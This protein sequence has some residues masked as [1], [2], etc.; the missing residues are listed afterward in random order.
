MA[1]K[2][3]LL[4]RAPG[5]IALLVSLVPHGAALPTELSHDTPSIQAPHLPD[6][7]VTAQ[8]DQSSPNVVQHPAAHTGGWGGSCTC[9]N[10]ET[11]W[12]GDLQDTCKNL[13]CFG[14]V[15]GECNSRVEDKWAYRAAFCAANQAE[16]TSVDCSNAIKSGWAIREQQDPPRGV[17][18]AW[19]VLTPQ[20]LYAFGSGAA[21]SGT[22]AED[23]DLRQV[24]NVRPASDI[25]QRPFSFAVE[26]PGR[27]PF[28]AIAMS[29]DDCMQWVLAIRK[30]KSALTYTPAK[31]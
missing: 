22:P 15:A 2:P 3:F 8:D 27:P 13:A 5:V 10:G 30:A 18:K 28:L 9:P 21:C 4:V 6:A 20:R 24:V 7:S 1:K 26:L 31:R 16:V 11:Y 17:S 23:I 25:T 14:G 19:L 12:V 29:D